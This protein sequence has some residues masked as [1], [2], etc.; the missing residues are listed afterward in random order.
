VLVG[1]INARERDEKRKWNKLGYY[2]TLAVG[3]NNAKLSKD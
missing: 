1:F 2:I 3:S